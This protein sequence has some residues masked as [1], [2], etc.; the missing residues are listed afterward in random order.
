MSQQKSNIHHCDSVL[1]LYGYGGIAPQT[2][3]SC[4]TAARDQRLGSLHFEIP[5]GGTIEMARCSAAT[6]FLECT[7][8]PVWLQVDHDMVFGRDVLG[9]LYDKAL[10]RKA[11]ITTL[12]LNR[13]NCEPAARIH[14][15]QLEMGDRLQ[16]I[17]YTG[18]SVSA[19]HRSVLEA[20][21]AN[22]GWTDADKIQ[23][24]EGWAWPF[25]LPMIAEPLDIAMGVQNK[26]RSLLL[27]DY[28][29]CHRANKARCKTFVYL[30]PRIGHLGQTCLWP[31]RDLGVA[32]RTIPGSFVSDAE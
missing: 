17:I 26:P 23:V 29:F 31:D 7:D 5:N 12:A 3:M 20:I 18:L 22:E 21:V 28:S 10:D 16:K 6:R 13:H 8:A 15:P 4:W 30:K 11:T 9:D 2:M 19:T 25:F 24:G 27:D 1:S 14:A 32:R